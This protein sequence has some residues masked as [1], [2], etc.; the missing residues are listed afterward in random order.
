[1]HDLVITSTLKSSRALPTLVI[2]IIFAFRRNLADE[3]IAGPP[4]GA[5]SS[6]LGPD[7]EAIHVA[8]PEFNSLGSHDDDLRRACPPRDRP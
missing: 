5:N 1:M 7:L 6:L 8:V 2:G 3:G 4:P